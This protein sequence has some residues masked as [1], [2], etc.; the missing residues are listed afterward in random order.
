MEFWYPG[1]LPV[2]FGER[3]ASVAAPTT[4][5]KALRKVD[6]SDGGR[7]GTVKEGEGR[8]KDCTRGQLSQAG[9]RRRR[10]PWVCQKLPWK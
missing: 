4:A 6:M 9:V 5:G 7:E 2:L 1:L 8:R 10:D 3:V